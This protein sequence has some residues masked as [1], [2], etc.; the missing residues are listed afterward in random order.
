[1]IGWL[2]TAWQFFS[3]LSGLDGWIQRREARQQ[4]KAE[5][6][7]ADALAQNERL[8]KELEAAANYPSDQDEIDRLNKGKF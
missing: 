8:K 1:M 5:Q 4:G 7:L 6:E 2:L 3:S